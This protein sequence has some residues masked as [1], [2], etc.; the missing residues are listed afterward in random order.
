MSDRF[1]ITFDHMVDTKPGG[2]DAGDGARTARRVEVITDG[3][4][5]RQWSTDEKA[6]ILFESLVPGANV[7]AVARCHGMSPQQLFGWR[8][9]AREQMAAEEKA[10]PSAAKPRGSTAK[11]PPPITPAFVPVM[12]AAQPASAAAAPAPSSSPPP[13]AAPCAGRIEIVVGDCLVRVGGDVDIKT[14]GVVLAAVRR[15]R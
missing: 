2:H 11:A 4:R 12:I 15:S 7:S 6:R 14:L 3:G 5:R 9:E 1:D 10:T 8:K 13:P